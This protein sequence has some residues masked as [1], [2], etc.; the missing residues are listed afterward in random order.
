MTQDSKTKSDRENL[1]GDFSEIMELTLE[2]KRE[3]LRILREKKNGSILL[4]DH[5][6]SRSDPYSQ[7]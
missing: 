6:V 4:V 3:L 5:P 1:P 2:E 7:R